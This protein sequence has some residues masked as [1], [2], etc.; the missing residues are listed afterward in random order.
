MSVAMK[1]KAVF[2][3]LCDVG[4]GKVGEAYPNLRGMFSRV[5]KT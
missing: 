3:V 4:W 2:G 5:V 1:C